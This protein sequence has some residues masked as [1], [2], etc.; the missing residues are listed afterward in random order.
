MVGRRRRPHNV[1][2]EL[3]AQ[4]ALI[5]E[6]VE[7]TVSGQDPGDRIRLHSI[8]QDDNGV[9]WNSVAVFETGD[10]GVVST[11]MSPSVGGTYTGL[12]P[13]GI[14][15]SMIDAAANGD[16]SSFAAGSLRPKTMTIA[17]ERS[18]RKLGQVELVRHFVDPSVEIREIRE[19]GI[20]ATLFLPPDG[21]PAPAVVTLGGSGGGMGGARETAA[22]LASHGFVAMSLAYFAM[23]DLPEHLIEIPLEYF[24]T[25][26]N[27]L[28]KHE[29]VGG[30]KVAISGV[31]RGGEL[32]LLLGS[33]FPEL[34]DG[35]IAWVPSAVMWAG[36]GPG[37]TAIGAPSWSLQGE[38]LPFMADRVT[39][40]QDAEI[41]GLEPVALTRRY[42]INLEDR[43]AVRAAGIAVERIQCPLLLISGEEDAMW[44][45]SLMSEM[46]VERL[47][48][49]NHQY[50]VRASQIRGSG[51]WH[52]GATS[53]DDGQRWSASNPRLSRRARWRSCSSCTSAEGSLARGAGI[54]GDDIGQRVRQ[55]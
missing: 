50:S 25:A 5:D 17:A 23:E 11:A 24:Q 29:A 12:D 49:H 38:P 44:P 33:T 1:R 30:N 28:R 36:I 42:L 22:L 13:A 6:A 54:L 55:R 41:L 2:I 35:I 19:E 8:M 32:V 20:V 39:P 40:E 43:D 37:N 47:E 18:G 48:E 52:P 34:I 4:S 14:Y 26:L 53:T 31:S 3:S 46:V 45:S 7:V 10:D 16:P 15:W 27:W 21:G 51:P 9:E